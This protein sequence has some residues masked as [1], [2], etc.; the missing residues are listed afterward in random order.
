MPQLRSLSRSRLSLL[1]PTEYPIPLPVLP[2][3]EYIICTVRFHVFLDLTFIAVPPVF[4]DAA[5]FTVRSRA[6]RS[7]ERDRRE[8]V[9]PPRE[10]V[11]NTMRSGRSRRVLSSGSR[12]QRTPSL[13]RRGRSRVET[14]AKRI[15]LFMESGQ[16]KRERLQ[17]G[18]LYVKEDEYVGIRR[19][20]M[21]GSRCATMRD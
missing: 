2:H 15:V 9:P 5:R 16:N 6:R 10:A 4:P 11:W 18:Y 8:R 12:S 20:R 21:R 13:S 19:E 14:W 3:D 7:I 1:Y 17:V